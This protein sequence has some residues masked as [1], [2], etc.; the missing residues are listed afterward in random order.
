[1]DERLELVKAEDAPA[2]PLTEER[3]SE[4]RYMRYG[5]IVIRAELLG[6]SG[7]CSGYLTNLSLGGSFFHAATLPPADS[8]VA[9]SFELPWEVGRCRVSARVVWLRAENDDPKRGCGLS[10]VE[11]EGDSKAR[12]SD[13]LERFEKL[14]ADVDFEA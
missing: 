6:P 7:P 3:S 13:Y 4:R 8:A 14:A 10:F 2:G 1:M 11:F 9:L 12:L 5:P